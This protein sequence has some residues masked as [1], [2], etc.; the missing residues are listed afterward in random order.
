MAGINPLAFQDVFGT[1]HIEPSVTG[2]IQVQTTEQA[3]ADLVNDVILLSPFRSGQPMQ[4]RRFSNPTALANYHD[5]DRIG[6]EGVALARVANSSLAGDGLFGAAD[7]L[8]VRVDRAAPSVSV[9]TDQ[10]NADLISVQTADYGNHT[11]RSWRKVEAGT[12]V[13]KKVT[14]GDDKRV[15]TRD[16]LGVLLSL[17]YTGNGSAAVV[18]IRRSA[19]HFEYTGQVTDGDKAVVNGVSFEFDDNNDT[20]LMNGPLS[21]DEETA[22]AADGYVVLDTGK[23]AVHIGADAAASFTNLALAITANVPGVNASIELADSRVL[24]DAPEEGVVASVAVGTA[25]TA[26]AAGDPAALRTT[27]TNASDGS[28]NLAIPLTSPSFKSIAVL[29]AYI[30]QQTGYAARVSPYANKF[31]PSAGLDVVTNADIKSAARNLTG[32]VAAIVDWINTGTRQNYTATALTAGEPQTDDAP[33]FFTG[34]TTPAVTSSDWED[35]LTLVG[36]QVELGGILVVDTDDPSIFR[37]VVDFI[38]EQRRVGK[39]FRAY[40]GAAPAQTTSD[41]LELAASLDS[42]RAHLFCQRLGVFAADGSVTYLHPLYLA[43]AMAGGAAGNRPWVNPLTNK[44][45]RFA[46][47]HEDDSFDLDTRESLLAGGVT[48][49]KREQGTIKVALHVTTS[50]DPD[51]RMPRI[52]SEIATVD[53]IDADVRFSFLQFRG[54]WA[55]THVAARVIGVLGQVLRRYKEEGA[56]VDGVDEFDQARSAWQLGNPPSV[57]EAGVLRLKYSVFIGGELNHISEVG[58]A[59]YQRLVGT[60]P[61][62]GGAQEFSTAVPIR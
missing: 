27:L 3:R 20:A 45:L 57:I 36:S 19:A 24:L 15:F 12:H 56:L 34:G 55:N 54:K 59:E 52:A 13:G 61:S 42:S 58:L 11:R 18:T 33:L 14:V 39:W 47:L 38:E 7:Y 60:L 21:Q 43:A 30:N 29:A 50:Q 16:D 10:S 35:A 44:R 48:V 6:D 23:V 28:A 26:T 5:P 8:T 22:I 25:W 46:A 62:S 41:Y 32:Y 17:Q 53:N 49:V 31:L 4:V 40:L 9:I 2:L 51:R 37:M 1:R